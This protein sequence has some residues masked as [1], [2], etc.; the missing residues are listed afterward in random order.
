MNGLPDPFGGN[1]VGGVGHQSPD[2][3]RPQS[4][5]S[6]E[7][8]RNRSSGCGT[9]QA[10]NGAPQTPQSMN[11]PPIMGGPQYPKPGMQGGMQTPNGG[12]TTH[13]KM[14]TPL[15]NGNSGAGTPLHNG[16]TTPLQNGFNGHQ[17]C[18]AATGGGGGL[19]GQNGVNCS[20]VNGVGSTSMIYTRN[21][22]ENILKS[23]ILISK[24]AT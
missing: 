16:A 9:P 24:A 6:I 21:S 14:P 22:Q 15:M 2:K 8:A 5:R 20:H 19:M 18:T 3:H 1:F 11:G 10:L 7:S 17:N 12:M 13:R 23:F 4:V